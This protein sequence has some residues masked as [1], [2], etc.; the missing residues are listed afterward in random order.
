MG[1]E[2][3]IPKAAAITACYIWEIAEQYVLAHQVDQQGDDLAA[4]AKSFAVAALRHEQGSRSRRRLAS[5]FIYLSRKFAPRRWSLSH[6]VEMRRNFRLHALRRRRAISAAT[7]RSVTTRDRHEKRAR[8]CGGDFHLLRSRTRRVS[9]RDKW[10]DGCIN[11][12]NVQGA[13][14]HSTTTRVLGGLEPLAPAFQQG[15]R[16]RTARMS[17]HEGRE[18]V[19]ISSA[20]VHYVTVRDL[21]DEVESR[22]GRATFL[23]RKGDSHSCSMS[24]WRAVG[25]SPC[26]TVRNGARARELENLS[27]RR[28]RCAHQ[29]VT[30]SI[31]RSPRS[32]EGAGAHQTAARFSAVVRGAAENLEP[33]RISGWRCLKSLARAAH[34]VS[35]GIVT[36]LADPGHHARINSCCWRA[37]L[38]RPRGPEGL[39]I[40][41]LSAPGAYCHSAPYTIIRR[42]FRGLD[43]VRLRFGRAGRVLGE[44]GH[45]SRRRRTL[46]GAVGQR[47]R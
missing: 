41:G 10:G 40:L 44:T 5:E 23:M 42:R 39:H 17:G 43:S 31:W 37:A 35:H 21:I 7:T 15:T 38:N 12:I 22:R 26:T 13:S 6:T 9:S 4:I 20:R 16:L 34:L 45:V 11:A 33:Q 29:S 36:Q 1:A 30:M 2:L 19:K 47:R 27:R 28:S 18:E 32:G 8:P 24:I 46:H 3:A 25:R 14:H